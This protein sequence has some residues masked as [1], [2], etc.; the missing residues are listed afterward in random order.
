L[1]KVLHFFLRH[2]LHTSTFL[3]GQPLISHIIMQYSMLNGAV[4]TTVIIWRRMIWD[5]AFCLWKWQTDPGR[6][7]VFCEVLLWH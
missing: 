3:H 1:S 7:R 4:W 5:S 2:I 6:D